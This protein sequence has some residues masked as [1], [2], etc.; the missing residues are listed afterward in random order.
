MLRDTQR[1]AMH[2]VALLVIAGLAWLLG[3]VLSPFVG[4]AIFAFGHLPGFVGVLLAV[5]LAAIFLVLLR[6][7]E[8]KYPDSGLYR[9]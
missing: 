1:Y 4:A 6:H 8:R 5:P 3:P 7:L 2:F 9:E